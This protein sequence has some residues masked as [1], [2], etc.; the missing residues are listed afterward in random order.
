MY[1]A[2]SSFAARVIANRYISQSEIQL[3]E[4][5]DEAIR[6]I[7]GEGGPKYNYGQDEM[8]LVSNIDVPTLKNIAIARSNEL[9]LTISS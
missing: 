1:R 2:L 6:S 8:N 7:Y 9:G 4:D 3:K 5:K